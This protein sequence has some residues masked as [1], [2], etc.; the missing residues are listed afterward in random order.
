MPLPRICI[1]PCEGKPFFARKRIEKSGKKDSEN[2]GQ[3]LY[4]IEGRD[5]LFYIL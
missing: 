2:F 5:A 1:D 3:S 4:L